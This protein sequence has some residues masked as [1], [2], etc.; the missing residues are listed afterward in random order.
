MEYNI[1]GE[2][3]L[4]IH[5]AETDSTNSYARREA[6]H[7]W[8][9]HPECQAFAVTAKKQT[10]GRGQRGTTWQSAEGKNLLMTIALRPDALAVSSYYTLSVAAALALKKSMKQFDLATMLKWPNDLYCNGCKLAGIL[11]ETECEGAYITQAFIGIGLNVNQI[12]FEKM[13]RRPTSMHLVGGKEYDINEVM[14]RV[15]ENFLEYNTA[16]TQ[17]N[18]DK[19]FEEY[20][21]SLMGYKTPMLYRDARGEFT[22]TIQGIQRDGSITLRCDNDET[23]TYKFKEIENVILGY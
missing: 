14:L 9:E 16:I 17:G 11:L 12:Q 7:L 21:K 13:S 15:I 18:A 3:V 10:C 20:E 6:L 23:R 1:K 22:A 2:K 5:L 19:L 4:H 8:H